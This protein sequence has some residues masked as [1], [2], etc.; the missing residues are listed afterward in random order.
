MITMVDR[1]KVKPIFS[2][3]V[4]IIRDVDVKLNYIPTPNAKQ[5]F[6]QLINDYKAGIR[7]FNIVG[8]YGT[9]K[10]SFLW[11]FEKNIN[12]KHSYF[13]SLNRTFYGIKRFEFLVLV[14]DFSSIIESFAK[15]L[16]LSSKTDFK[17][18]EVIDQLDKYCKSLNKAGKGLVIV[19]DEFGKFLEYAAKNNPEKELYFVQQLSEYI[20]NLQKHIF[21][22]TTL[23]QDFNGYSRNLTKTQQNEWDKV[24]GRL[25][26]ITFN[27]P[28]EQ[29]L[30]LASERLSKLQLGV[31][32]KN[33][34]KL[35]K[36]IENAK[37]FPLKD[38]FN[39]S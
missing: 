20:N 25:K 8:T 27:E 17:I 5:V 4:N 39:E 26:E 19:I 6:N 30:F 22:I 15:H 1:K 36:S 10:S 11:A 16:G 37:A 31:K 29:L 3:S 23:H 2:P 28:V 18:N 32:D 34:S 7:S 14:G 13:A 35:F 24:K 9:G 33:F 21:F 38:Y 12:Q